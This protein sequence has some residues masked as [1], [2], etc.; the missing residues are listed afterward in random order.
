M[1]SQL[2]N[3]GATN[4]QAVNSGSYEP[5]HPSISQSGNSKATTSTTNSKFIIKEQLPMKRGLTDYALPGIN[6]FFELLN[7]L[8]D[9]VAHLA[10]FHVVNNCIPKI[11]TIR[12]NAL[13]GF[14]SFEFGCKWLDRSDKIIERSMALCDKESTTIIIQHKDSPKTMAFKLIKMYDARFTRLMEILNRSIENI[15]QDIATEDIT[16]EDITTD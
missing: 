11:H 15:S 2:S 14:D 8:D 3:L 6:N 7:T 1:G 12:S 10:H 4:I 13:I 5:L 16:T 9:R